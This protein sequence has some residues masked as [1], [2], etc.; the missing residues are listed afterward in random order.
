MEMSDVRSM[1]DD[2]K[3][4]ADVKF[5]DKET[6]KKFTAQSGSQNVNAL[7]QVDDG[8]FMRRSTLV[9]VD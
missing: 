5:C 3:F 7:D 4:D 6:S 2:A 1:N 9:T 8:A